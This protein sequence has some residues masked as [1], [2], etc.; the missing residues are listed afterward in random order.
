[1]KSRHVKESKRNRPAGAL[2][3]DD[4]TSRRMSRMPKAA[5]GPEQTVAGLL[6]RNRIE[7]ARDN[8]DLPGNPDFADRR[9]RWAM[10]VNGCFWHHHSGCSRATVP[11]RNTQFWLDK[12]EA[13]RKRDERAVVALKEGGFD[14]HV[15]WECEIATAE[16]HLTLRRLICGSADD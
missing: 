11:K 12:F 3:T 15:L 13:N 7:Y 1:M 4:K 9:R 6:D 2:V 8:K 10:F 14:V 5:T 16:H